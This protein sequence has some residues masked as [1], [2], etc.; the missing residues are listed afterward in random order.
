M[1]GREGGRKGGWVGEGKL[2]SG[3]RERRGTLRITLSIFS[4]STIVLWVGGI[5]L[6]QIILAKLAFIENSKGK[7]ITLTNQ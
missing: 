2:A 5:I 7:F 3:E 1:G 6:T 4:H